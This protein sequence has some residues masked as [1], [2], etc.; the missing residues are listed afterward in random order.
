MDFRSSPAPEIM[1]SREVSSPLRQMTDTQST[2]EVDGDRT[3]RANT[4]GGIGGEKIIS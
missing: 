3:P 4:H 1:R 2:Q